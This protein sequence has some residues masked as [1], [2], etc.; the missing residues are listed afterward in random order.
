MHREMAAHLDRATDRLVAR[1]LSPTEAHAAAT[2]EFGNVT[3]LKEEGRRAR[4]A[5]WLDALAADSRFAIRHFRRTP[6]ATVTMLVVLAIGM[7]ISTAL[8]S[9]VH[10]YA[11]QPPL[12]VTGSDDLVRIRGRELRGDGVRLRWFTAEELEEYQRL[13]SHFTAVAGYAS[14]GVTLYMERDVVRTESGAATFVTPNYFDFLGV[15]PVIGAGLPQTESTGAETQL[16]AVVSYGVWEQFFSR[17]PDAIGATL[18]VDGVPVTIVGV[19]PPGFS[20]LNRYDEMAVWMPM[21][22]RPLVVSGVK[23][24]TE[25]LAAAARLAPGT[26]RQRAIA[27]VDVIAR[28]VTAVI[29]ETQPP[30]YERRVGADVVPLLATNFSPEFDSEVLY[31]GIAASVLGILLLLVTCTNVS[32]LQTGLA[33]MRRREISIRLAMGASRRRIVRQLLTETVILATLAGGLGLAIVWLIQRL[34]VTQIPDVSVEL[35]VS[36]PVLAFV[37]GTALAVGTLF[38][39]SPALHATRLGLSSALK[40]SNAAIAAPRVRLQ[41]G[42]VIAQIALTQ[43]LIIVLAVSMVT[44]Y[45]EYQRLGLDQSREQLVAMRLR[46][47]GEQ[48]SD[49]TPQ[50]AAEMRALRDR[51]RGMPSIEGAVQDLEHTVRLEQYGVHPDDRAGGGSEQSMRITGPMIAPGYFGV[52]GMRVILGRDFAEG[53]RTT[54]MDPKYA[55]VEVPVI[56]GSDLAADLW[57]GANPLGRRL[58]YAPDPLGGPPLTVVGVLEPQPHDQLKTKNEG[59]RVFFPPDSARAASSLVMMIRTSGD[60]RSLIP[61]IRTVVQGGTSRLVITDTR[62]VADREL[63]MR[64]AFTLAGTSLGTAGFLMLFL[65]AIG[66]Y[67]V[68]SFAVG[69]RT[70]EIAVR[71]AVGARGGQIVGK[72][73]GEGVRLGIIGLAIGLPLSL[74][75]L[76]ILWE[77]SNGP[78]IPV[79]GIT[80]VAGLGVLVVALTATWLPARRA[81]AVDPATVLRRD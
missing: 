16:V 12:G 66:L 64:E 24:R 68:V 76:R 63:E 42:L 28:R 33:L 78:P 77:T 15:R 56:V 43:P 29:E 65:A 1:G 41:R 58:R 30:P 22:S 13:T 35:A 51:L 62:T 8:F 37:F 23:P 69:Q 46:P 52:M 81:A 75:G 27:A 31:L 7:S 34:L 49:A 54:P 70:S 5:R 44:V 72:F 3:Y 38:G 48:S 21:A 59:Y 40:D 55:R 20:G 26:D 32:A 67:A 73:I 14:Y 53:D 10:A 50:W 47:A 61:T 60:G 18:T 36:G 11:N 25:N 74:I 71:M 2:R 57:P 9:F 80:G 19:V 4:G 17:S 45:G 39:L 6:G 79:A